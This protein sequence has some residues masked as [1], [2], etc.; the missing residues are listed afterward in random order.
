MV[1]GGKGLAVGEA[2]VLPNT[3]DGAAVHATASTGVACRRAKMPRSHVI[4]ATRA[5]LS[6]E[7]RLHLRYICN[8]KKRNTKCFME[9]EWG[10]V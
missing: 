6:E 3:V 8:F 9:D 7:M 10:D 1:D 2:S 5:L 4:L